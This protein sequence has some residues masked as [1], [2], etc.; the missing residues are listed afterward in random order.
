MNKCNTNR[1]YDSPNQHN[2]TLGRLYTVLRLF[3]VLLPVV[4]MLNTTAQVRN[5]WRSIFDTQGRLTRMNFF[6]EGEQIPDSNYFFQY[7]SENI[8]KGMVKGELNTQ[9]GCKKG[10][11]FLFNDEGNLTNYNISNNGQIVLNVICDE[12]GSCTSAWSDPFDSPTDLWEGD[13]MLVQSGE[14][15]LFSKYNLAAA[16]Y[17][18]PGSINIRRPFNMQILIPKQANSSKQGVV[19]GWK[20]PD[21]YYLFEISYGKYFSALFYENGVLNKLTESRQP[22]TNEADEFI[23]LKISNNGRAFI[24]DVNG[25]IEFIMPIPSFKGTQLGL[26][27][28]AR[29]AARFADMKINYPMDQNDTFYSDKWIGKGTG[30]F[31]APDK[32]LTTYD[33][34]ALSNTLRV[35]G[36]VDGKAFLVSAKILQAEE[37]SNLAVLQLDRKVLPE[38]ELGSIGISDQ[39]YTDETQFTSVGYPHSLSGILDVPQHFEGKKVPSSPSRPRSLAIEMP[40]RYGMIG[41]P[42]FDNSLNF[43]GI[44]SQKSYDIN[45]S[46]IID[47]QNNE[48]LFKGFSPKFSQPVTSTISSL[49]KDDQ[50][51]KLSNLVVIIESYIFETETSED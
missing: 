7:H 9:S 19:L 35:K 46:E 14:L 5:G 16:I 27:S 3:L 10:S 31:I 49:N 20:D 13:S 30:F 38:S 6:V 2:Q 34:I 12:Y 21:N 25:S 8:L 29:G 33:N 24:F 11:V 45:Y 18:P 36:S 26:V 1:K 48:M 4:G 47:Y 50:I 37:R 22:I 40:F 51:R 44:V 15:K 43:M 41:S 32:I 23:V 39:N 28:R 42:V 17:N